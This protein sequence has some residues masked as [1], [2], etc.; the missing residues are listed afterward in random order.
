MPVVKSIQAVTLAQ[1]AHV[2]DLAD[3]KR[4]GEEM[5]E[6]ARAEAERILEAARRESA[7]VAQDAN[8]RGHAEG[9]A[10]GLQEG[11]AAGREEGRAEAVEAHSRELQ[12]LT[13]RWY[14][15]LDEWETERTTM[16]ADAR[17][18]MVRF[19]IALA[20]RIVGRA[21][22]VEPS[23]VVDQVQAA[24]GLVAAAADATLSVHSED[25]AL[26]RSALS[27]IVARIGTLQHVTLVTDDTLE[28][29]GCVVRTDR[30]Q[31]DATIARQF[32]RI[33]EALLPVPADGSAS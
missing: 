12:A 10:R 5:V 18:D 14:A 15:A 11:R 33:A 19:A 28:R 21:L 7:E 1:G 2:L 3:M 6:N 24:L 23:L 4:L 20:E 31:V 17:E 22:E 13:T 8:D 30:G 9:H 25:E 26:V 29:G 27:G 32:N 16:L